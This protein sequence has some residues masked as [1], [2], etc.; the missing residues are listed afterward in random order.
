MYQR[1][2]NLA[3]PMR[4]KYLKDDVN[5]SL[6]KFPEIS[7]YPEIFRKLKDTFGALI[8]DLDFTEKKFDSSSK[9]ER[10]ALYQYLWD[11]G[12]FSFWLAGFKD[13]FY[14]QE[15]NDEVYDF[16]SE[17]IRAR[18]DDPVKKDLLAPKKAPHAWGTKRPCLEQA[19]YE[20]YNQPNVDLINVKESPILEITETGVKTKN[21]GVIDV[22]V[23]IL[24]T[25]FDSVTGGILDI[26]ITNG[27]GVT[28][29]EKWRGEN[30]TETY[31][32]LSTNGF[33][34]TYWFYGPHGPTAFSNGP[35]SGGLQ[36]D[37]VVDL[38]VK[39]REEG[40]TRVEAQKPSEKEWT[41]ALRDEWYS[42]LFPPTDSWYQGANIPGKKREPLNYLGGIPAYI[43]ELEKSKN[44]NYAGFTIV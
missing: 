22:D 35:T 26:K 27:E 29:Q 32:G 42:S 2:P 16:W 24:A 7:R 6:W 5:S 39:M 21:E 20:V 8:I 37:W 14:V 44:N 4:Q 30:G 31:L 40:K 34:N 43:E 15:A 1:T 9:Q 3:I 38:M 18:I 28:I 17:N 12:G 41:K 11:Y 19:Y 13:I 10:L 36:A 33:P 23:L 25:G